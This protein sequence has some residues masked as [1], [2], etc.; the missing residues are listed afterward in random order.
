LAGPDRSAAVGALYARLMGVADREV[1]MDAIE[2][3]VAAGL[4]AARSDRG[5]PGSH[6]AWR[7]AYG[8][9]AA[10]LAFE[11][12]GDER[13]AA[14]LAGAAAPVL[15]MRDSVVGR[16]DQCRARVGAGWS[17]GGVVPGRI[18]TNVTLAGRIAEPLAHL[19]ALAP[20]STRLRAAAEETSS[21]V[22]SALREFDDSYSAIGEAGYYPVACGRRPEPLNHLAAFGAAL[23]RLHDAT[24]DAD[25]L[26]RAAGLARWFAAATFRDRDGA[27]VWRYDPS[28]GRPRGRGPEHVWKAQVTVHF[29]A[30]A[31]D[32]G[33]VE[34][35]V[36]EEVRQTLSNHVFRPEGPAATI[37]ADAEPLSD[38]RGVRGG[39]SSLL[40]LN[41]LGGD[42]AKAVERLVASD[43][44]IG[45]WFARP[46]GLTAYAGRIR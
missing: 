43:P 26:A 23:V 1:L 20:R 39:A 2:R 22:G 13:F 16:V 28:P 41:E 9:A 8:A 17:S 3:V 21:A 19:V 27:L 46:H 35:S 7:W 34:A 40:P 45:G 31:A 15:E 37:E 11:R 38:Y 5:G 29:I 18:T 12:T 33:L 25:L 30:L 44:G 24:G 42:V 4:G 14:A 6:L 10:A 32:H 36:L